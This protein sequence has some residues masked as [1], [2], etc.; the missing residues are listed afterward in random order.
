MLNQESKMSKA[1]GKFDFFQNKPK[2]NGAHAPANTISNANIRYTP[3][4]GIV[5]P[6]ISQLA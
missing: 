2:V 3:G 6:N 1:A 4:R 5:N